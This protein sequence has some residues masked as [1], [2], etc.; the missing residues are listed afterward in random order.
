MSILALNENYN[1]VGHISK[2]HIWKKETKMAIWYSD[3]DLG[4]LFGDGY[5]KFTRYKIIY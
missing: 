3:N 2:I 1:K 5:H 4:Q